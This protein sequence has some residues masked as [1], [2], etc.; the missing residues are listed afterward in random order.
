MPNLNQ[1]L[2]S[3]FNNF[4]LIDPSNKKINET[5]KDQTLILS[6]SINGY[7]EINKKT[8]KNTIPKLLLVPILISSWFMKL[9]YR[10]R[11]D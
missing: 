10:F 9:I 2:F 7:I 5:I 8:I 6:P 11:E 3:G 4:E 1:I